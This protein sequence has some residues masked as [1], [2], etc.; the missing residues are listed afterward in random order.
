MIIC[1]QELIQ[2]VARFM[3]ISSD[4]LLN[5]GLNEGG[6]KKCAFFFNGKLAVSERR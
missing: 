3:S 5:E 4:F 1:E 6:R 2:A